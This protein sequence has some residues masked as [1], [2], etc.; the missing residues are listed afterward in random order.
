VVLIFEN[1]EGL[2]PLPP[3]PQKQ[4]IVFHVSLV[5]NSSFKAWE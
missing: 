4:K 1:I 5:V 2:A 3:P